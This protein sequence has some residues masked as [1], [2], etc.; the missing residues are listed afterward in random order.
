MMSGGCR[1]RVLKN[2]DCL[3]FTAAMAEPVP[4]ASPVTRT[5]QQHR[6]LYHSCSQ[7]S[8]VSAN[9]GAL[10]VTGTNIRAPI[11]AMTVPKLHGA[12]NI[13]SAH[14]TKK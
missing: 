4:A 13:S 11:I 5:I 7:R 9:T 8:T 12:K 6:Y 2:Q 10:L 3:P 14:S 1:N